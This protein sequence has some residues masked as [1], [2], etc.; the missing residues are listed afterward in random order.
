M[1]TIELRLEE[2]GFEDWAEREIIH[3]GNDGPPIRIAVLRSG[4]VGGE[5]SVAFGFDLGDKVVIA[6]TSLALLRVAMRAINAKAETWDDWE[7]R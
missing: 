6:E 3:L 2:P 4:M 7:E 5:T 1:P